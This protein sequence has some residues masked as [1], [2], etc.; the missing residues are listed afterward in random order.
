[1]WLVAQNQ[2]V[3]LRERRLGVGFALLVREFHFVDAWRKS[4]HNRT[5]LAAKQPFAR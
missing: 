2:E 5:D 3:I 1:M 4:L